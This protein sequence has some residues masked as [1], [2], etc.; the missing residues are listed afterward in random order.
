MRYPSRKMLQVEKDI[1]RT[2]LL[3]GESR[4]QIADAMLISLKQVD[5]IQA[6]L[7]K[8]EQKKVAEEAK[9]DAD[10]KTLPAM[11][12]KAYSAAKSRSGGKILTRSQFHQLWQKQKGRCEFTGI[13]F[14]DNQVREDAKILS[15]PW[16][17]SLD[18]I[19]THRRYEH[20]NVRI[21]A[22]IVN[23]GLGEWPETTFREMC[24]L[25]SKG[26]K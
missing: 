19:D 9:G 25:V 6:A 3:A 21:L 7:T 17:P 23:F 26:K 10:W 13:V 11:A 20:D 4:E 1:V 5:G 24:K 14:N 2:R 22:Q 16:R 15:R 18:R 12:R 8:E